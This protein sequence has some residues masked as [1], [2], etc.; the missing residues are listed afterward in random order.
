MQNIFKFVKCPDCQFVCEYPVLLL[1]CNN[2]VCEK[3]IANKRVYFCQSCQREHELIP[4][5]CIP[6][7]S[8]QLIIDVHMGEYK[9]A[10][11]SCNLLSSTIGE[12]ESLT[13]EPLSHIDSTVSDLKLRFQ[14]KKYELIMQIETNFEEIIAKIDEYHEQC[15]SSVG[16]LIMTLKKFECKINESK[17]Y[18]NML[19]ERLKN[20]HVKSTCKLISDESNQLRG[21]LASEVDNLKQIL[22][23]NELKNLN[24]KCANFCELKFSTNSLNF[25]GTGTQLVK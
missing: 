5:H 12:L 11:E 15:K 20:A 1:P 16:I 13:S 4:N 25:S 22:L 19:N 7:K 6:N 10:L 8:M 23:T 17:A 3:H 9:H 18:L 2:T 21:N 14:S 24:E